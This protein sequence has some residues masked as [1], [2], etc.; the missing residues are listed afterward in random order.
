MKFHNLKNVINGEKIIFMIFGIPLW[1]ILIIALVLLIGWKIIKFAIKLLIVMF[2]I[3]LL[4]AI[5]Y[6]FSGF[7]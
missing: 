4:L 1:V 3:L 7:F 5:I 2:V 6:I